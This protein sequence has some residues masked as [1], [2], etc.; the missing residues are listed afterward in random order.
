[1]SAL[2]TRLPG[3]RDSLR[4]G[5]AWAVGAATGLASAPGLSLGDAGPPVAWPR[6]RLL[7]GR[8][9]EAPAQQ[10]RAAVI[11]FFA[12]TCSYCGRHNQHVQRLLKA[13]ADLPLQ[14]LGVAHDR[15]ADTV[16]RHLAA[17]GWT[18]DV[19]LDEQPLH[20]VLSA[21]RVTPLTCVLDRQGRL[22]EVIPGEMF[23]DDVMG[24]AR[25]ARA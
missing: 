15:Q 3:R 22:R 9:M 24:L 19:T 12:T 6:V 18:F 14:V 2:S 5:L 21:R 23:A 20:A 7:D 11:V 8:L 1:M 17:Q 13:S 16:Q 10:H 4:A 25:W